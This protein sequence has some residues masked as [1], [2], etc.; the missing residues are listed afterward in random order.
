MNISWIDARAYPK[1]LFLNTGNMLIAILG[2]GR[3]RILG[4][5][6]RMLCETDILI[7]GQDFLD[8]P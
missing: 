1:A 6:W 5:L 8:P 3:L 4:K 2:G 7:V